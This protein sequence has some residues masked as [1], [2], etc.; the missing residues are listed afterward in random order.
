MEQFIE[1]TAKGTDNQYGGKVIL[2]LKI[3]DQ[4]CFVDNVSL[5]IASTQKGRGMI[6]IEESYEE[7]KKKLKECIK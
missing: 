6:E 3:I 7:I 1:L 5:V 4:F 2:N